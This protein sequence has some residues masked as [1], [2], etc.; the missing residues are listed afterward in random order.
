MV[1]IYYIWC[2][3]IYM[4]YMI[5]DIYIYIYIYDIYDIYDIYI[6]Y[7]WYIYM[8]YMMYM[9]YIYDIYIY[10]IYMIFIY[11]YHFT[12]IS[13]CQSPR[14]SIVE[15]YFQWPFEALWSTDRRPGRWWTH[16][17]MSTRRSQL[18]DMSVLPATTRLGDDH[19]CDPWNPWNP[20]KVSRLGKMNIFYSKAG[21]TRVALQT[22]SHFASFFFKG[23]FFFPVLDI[24]L[25]FSFPASLL[26][27]F[28][29][30]SF[31]A[32]PC[33]CFYASHAYINPK[34]HNI[35]TP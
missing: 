3:Y 19:L 18:V 26:F 13:T 35:N 32:F 34:M 14:F 23:L 24:F 8:I 17:T 10:M 33:F 22:L 1:Y 28:S 29:A 4:I 16:K 7:I 31:S 5:Y 6:W 11:V 25:D 21:E 12:T 2:I 15:S 30:F 20:W 27:C 9:I